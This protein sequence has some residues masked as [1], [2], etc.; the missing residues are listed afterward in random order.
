MSH[1]FWGVL[2]RLFVFLVGMA[3]LLLGW[4]YAEQ[5]QLLRKADVQVAA[6]NFIEALNTYRAAETHYNTTFLGLPQGALLDMFSQFGFA[7]RSYIQLRLAE[8]AFREGERL[9]ALTGRLQP[10]SMH[11][12]AHHPLDGAVTDKPSIQEAIKFFKLAAAQYK[13]TQ[14]HTEDPYWQ[15]VAHANR[16]R[17]MLQT[18][19]IQTFLQEP[20]PE[21]LSLKQKLVDAIKSLQNALNAVY[22]DQVRVAFV[23]ERSLVLLLEALTRFQ[24]SPDVEAAERRSVERFFRDTLTDPDTAPL[25]EIL[26]SS[27][28]QSLS[29]QE[30]E[31]MRAFL[32]H[33]S[34]SSAF[35]EQSDRPGRGPR[36][37][38][39]SADAGSEGRTH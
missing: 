30:E 34:P 38:L 25:G 29:R 11:A 26:R 6:G 14:E 12:P 16:A 32:L 5:Q 36:T 7:S 21:P 23:E 15:F 39:G 37:G 35:R 3:L 4:L 28:L 8:V 24:R 33:Q 18:F 2:A 19:L 20:R 17:A 13:K 1:K 27:V 31:S 10:M 22:T 9:L